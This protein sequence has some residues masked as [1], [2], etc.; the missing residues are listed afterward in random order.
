MISGDAGAIVMFLEYQFVVLFIFFMGLDYLLY[1]TLLMSIADGAY[2]LASPI[3]VLDLPA[4]EIAVSIYS[5]LY[6]FIIAGTFPIISS[7]LSTSSFVFR[8]KYF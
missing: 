1:A 4:Y 2:D 3:K 5:S 8:F 6:L 7:M